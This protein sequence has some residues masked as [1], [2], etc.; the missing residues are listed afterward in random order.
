MCCKGQRLNLSQSSLSFIFDIMVSNHRWHF[1]ELIM[2][3]S[4]LTDPFLVV[5]NHLKISLTFQRDDAHTHTSWRC[6]PVLM[7]L[8]SGYQHPCC[9][10]LCLSSF[11][12]STRCCAQSVAGY[13]CAPHSV[14]WPH[15]SPL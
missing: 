8:R 14:L 15:P 3:N 12:L 5:F 6:S 11:L 1:T 9:T 2:H 4:V 7:N 10:C 13:R